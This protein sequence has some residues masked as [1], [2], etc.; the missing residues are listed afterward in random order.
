MTNAQSAG[1][2]AQFL[3]WVED[4]ADPANDG[5][6]NA[7]AIGR[8]LAWFHE[9]VHRISVD[10]DTGMADGW[11]EIAE[12][13]NDENYQPLSGDTPAS[14]AEKQKCYPSDPYANCPV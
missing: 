9:Q 14:D 1:P 5:D 4:T 2:V 3:R 13:H 7:L 10:E 6:R 8:A 11:T 12:L